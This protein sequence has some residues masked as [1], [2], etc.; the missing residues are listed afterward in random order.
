MS[1]MRI[2]LALR[3]GS[4]LRAWFYTKLLASQFHAIG[5]G[6]RISP[7]FRFANL[8]NIDLGQNVFVGPG[9]WMHAI[10]FSKPGAPA[11]LI[12]ESH[13]G[14]GM[15]ATISAAEQV[16]IEEYVLLARNV[17]ISDH[18]HA[19]EDVAVPI[20]NQGIDRIAPVR[21]GRHSWIGQNVAVLPGARI[22]MHCVI[23]AN[24]VVK[25]IIPDFSVAVGAPARV[26][27]RY[28]HDSK[29]WLKV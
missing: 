10:G 7:P 22:G 3:A 25:S 13:A 1:G 29:K 2:E 16:I 21:I 14:I 6:S 17:Y 4:R 11:A 8:Q 28:D 5:P 20:M 15:G 23:G 19:F 24:S 9:C 27:K 18:S 26:V 12:I